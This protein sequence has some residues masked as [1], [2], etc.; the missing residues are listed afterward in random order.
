MIY[1]KTFLKWCLLIGGL[2]FWFT[3]LVGIV[4]STQNDGHYYDCSI[5][6]ISPDFPIEAREECRRLRSVRRTTET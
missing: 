5:A 6:E 2:I 3:A 1:V 4:S